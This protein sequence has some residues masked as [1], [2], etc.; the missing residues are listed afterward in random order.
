MILY[1][2]K[3]T[4]YYRNL[5]KANGLPDLSIEGCARFINIIFLEGAHHISEI[6]AE[7]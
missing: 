1:V 5:I 2:M 3:F 7:R 4:S 6:T